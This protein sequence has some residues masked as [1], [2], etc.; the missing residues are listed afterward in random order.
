MTEKPI[1]YLAVGGIIGSTHKQGVKMKARELGELTVETNLTSYQ[2]ASLLQM[3]PCSI[4]KWVNEGK[5]AAF[6]TPGGHRRIKAGDLALFVR[7]HSMDAAE[8]IRA[9]LADVAE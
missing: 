7:E 1:D 2:A 4:N 8:P 9:L 3:S 6:R 5:L